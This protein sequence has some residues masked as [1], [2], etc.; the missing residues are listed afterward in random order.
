MKTTARESNVLWYG[1]TL[2]T[3]LLLAY[4]R[5]LP[6]FRGKGTLFQWIASF[7]FHG[8]LHVRNKR[9]ACLKIDPADLIGRTISFEGGFEPKSLAL[10]A[11]IM[12]DGGVF[13]D[14]GCNFGLYTSSLGILPNVQCIAIDGSF[15][16]LA[17]LK[18]N[19][20]KNPGINARIVNCAL[21]SEKQLQ[22]FEVAAQRNL[23]STR[24]TNDES[25]ENSTRFWVAGAILQEVLERLS[26]G[27]IKLLK[28]DVE[29]FEIP[30][31]KG[32]DFNGPFRPENL[33][34]ECD[35]EILPDAKASIEFLV[36]NGYEARTIQG[37]LIRD[38]GN[39]PENNVWC[40]DP[41][42]RAS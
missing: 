31:F 26:P 11:E 7:V 27:R 3:K 10:A 4:C 19:L 37:E 1:D 35:L 36:A 13:V 21:A 30:V 38:F 28:I 2:P 12:S 5:L 40:H 42:R 15:V 22:C 23:G 8:E 9:G 14:V 33:I 25:V 6:Y 34:V 32:L 24:I 41:K 18:E 39:L 16:A 17:K 29:G 20:R